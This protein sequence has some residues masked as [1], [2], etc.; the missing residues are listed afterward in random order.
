MYWIPSRRVCM[1]YVCMYVGV[2]EQ[3]L[4]EPAAREHHC[5]QQ[6]LSEC[7]QLISCSHTCPDECDRITQWGR[8]EQYRGHLLLSA[9]GYVD[10]CM[11]VC[12]YVCISCMYVF[13]N[14]CIILCI[15]NHT[16]TNYF[17]T[18]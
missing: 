7:K 18:K 17:F 6:V 16:D 10:L 9:P 1:M 5:H 3:D 14:D 11:Y 8:P 13:K 15:Q 2:Y 12:M 4:S